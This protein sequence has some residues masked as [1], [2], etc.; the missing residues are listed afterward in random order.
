MRLEY[1]IMYIYLTVRLREQV[2]LLLPSTA[3]GYNY[4]IRPSPRD[5]KM[6]A[7][8]PIQ[9]PHET[10]KTTCT[11]RLGRGLLNEDPDV[12]KRV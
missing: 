11:P 1:N 4:L 12:S 9:I 10:R 5:K 7:F 2:D 3:L 6:H 8:S